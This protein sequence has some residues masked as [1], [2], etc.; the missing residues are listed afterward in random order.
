MITDMLKDVITSSKGT[1]RYANI[2][3]LYQAG[4]TGTNSY[5]SDVSSKFPSSADM[6]SWFNGYTKNYSITVW[7]GYDH[8]YETGNYLTQSSARIASYF[9]KYAMTYLA[10]GKPNKNWKKPSNVYT[11]TVNG[12]RELYLAGSTD[13][14]SSDIESSSIASSVFSSVD[15]SS[16]TS[17]SIESSSSSISSSSTSSSSSDSVSST[18]ASSENNS[19]SDSTESS[20]SSANSATPSN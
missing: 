16:S 9:Y 20:S 5:P 3:G 17:S 8:Q 11:K 10:Q 7:V 14:V 4:K 12:V 18:S 2:S 6:D 1:G 13:T 15:S 19:T